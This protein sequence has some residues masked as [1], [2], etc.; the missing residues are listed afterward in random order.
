MF[1]DNTNIVK[2]NSSFCKIKKKVFFFFMRLSFFVFTHQPPRRGGELVC[3]SGRNERRAI[4]QAVHSSARLRRRNSN[5]G[6]RRVNEPIF[7][8]KTA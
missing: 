7:A 4:C 8:V 5:A 3:C 2:L 6:T 1:I